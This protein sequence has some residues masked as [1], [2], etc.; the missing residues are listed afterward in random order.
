MGKSD[1]EWI[2]IPVGEYRIGISEE[3]LIKYVDSLDAHVRKALGPRPFALA[4]SM[5]ERQIFLS[6]FRVSAEPVRVD[7]LEA[8]ASLV[9]GDDFEIVSECEYPDDPYER[10]GGDDCRPARRWSYI[11]CAMGSG[12]AYHGQAST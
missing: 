8:L 9:P 5:P 3:E 2:T 6:A 4:V 10:G 11:G 1:R 12:A 7:D